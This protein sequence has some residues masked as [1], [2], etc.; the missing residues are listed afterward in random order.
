MP[1]RHRA[2]LL[3]EPRDAAAASVISAVARRICSR[4][5]WIACSS[6]R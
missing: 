6:L 4:P 5:V 2:D 3:T 1:V